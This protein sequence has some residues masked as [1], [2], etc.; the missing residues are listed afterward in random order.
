MHIKDSN[1]CIVEALLLTGYTI[2][3]RNFMKEEIIF[4]SISS[5]TIP[6]T[7]SLMCL[8]KAI[9]IKNSIKI[10]WV[11]HSNHSVLCLEKKL[12]RDSVTYY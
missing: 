11:I 4:S 12:K 5:R 3:S 9:L 2:K 8:K 6:K 10:N 1:L 7:G